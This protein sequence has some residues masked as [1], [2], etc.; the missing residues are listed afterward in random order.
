MGGRPK[1]PREFD[2]RF[3]AGIRAGLPVGTAALAAGASLT[4]GRTTFREAGGVNPTGVAGPVG[5]YLS[6]S[7]REEIAWLDHAAHG[8]RDIAGRIGRS[9]GTISRELKR[10]DT[11]R[12][13]RASVGQAK[14][15]S[16]RSTPRAA[17]LATNL[18]LR[19]EVQARQA[20]G[21]SRAD[22]WQTQDRL[23]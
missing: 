23:P 8:V 10:G 4:W 18:R 22:R 21:Q 2:R 1:H 20:Q 6:W 16:A 14:A 5:R 9:P 19:A 7:E 17:K 12:G 11:S 15:D 13:Y 3:W